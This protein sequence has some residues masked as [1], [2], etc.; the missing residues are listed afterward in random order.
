MGGG[1]EGRGNLGGGGTF[2]RLG[3][4]G[5]V[6]RDLDLVETGDEGGGDCDRDGE[7]YGEGEEFRLCARVEGRSEDWGG[8]RYRRRRIRGVTEGDTNLLK[9]LRVFRGPA[10]RMAT[11]AFRIDS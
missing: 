10:A 5:V 8:G 7:R 11:S 3:V 4:G 6:S 1:G 9:E 2:C